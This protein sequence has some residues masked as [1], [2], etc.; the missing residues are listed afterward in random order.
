MKFRDFME[1]SFVIA[2]AKHQ[3]NATL[4]SY[5]TATATRD[6]QKIAQNLFKYVAMVELLVKYALVRLK[7]VKKPRSA[8]EMVKE[9]YGVVE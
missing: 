9:T 3:E 1:S 4:R 5:G 7:L 8:E 6:L 2:N